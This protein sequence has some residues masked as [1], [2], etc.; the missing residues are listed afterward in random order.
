MRIL[1]FLAKIVRIYKL[2]LELVIESHDVDVQ[3]A[4]VILY[5]SLKIAKSLAWLAGLQ[6][7]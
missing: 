3:D 2:F 6:L 1:Y 4:A 7:T 5:F